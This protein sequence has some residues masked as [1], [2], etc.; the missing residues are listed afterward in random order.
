MRGS[1]GF[2]SA[3]RS[4][5]RRDHRRRLRSGQLT[6]EA[7]ESRQ[8]LTALQMTDNEQL[9]VELLNR[10]RMDPGGEAQRL[11][12][13]LNFDLVDGTLKPDPRQ[14]L[15]PQQMLIDS[16][17][18]H[19]QDMLDRNYFSHYTAGSK[20]GPQQRAE[21]LGYTG[22]VGEN[23]SWGGSTEPID[24]L[25]QVYDRHLNLWR[26][27]VHRRNLLDAGYDELG[28]GVR[29]GQY[30][31]GPTYNAS[32]VV[33]DFG[34]VS[35]KTYITGVVYSDLDNDQFYEDRKSTRL[36]SSHSSVSRMPS[37]A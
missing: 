5:L 28:V 13:D 18:A 3:V 31:S 22:F 21:L 25:E 26:S 15:A 30:V 33:T 4:I 11:G 20:N 37:S 29:Y 9:L 27:S 36:N 6:A 1:F 7:L 32:M 24:Q 35:G 14:P 23:L 10:A 19:A 34:K 16:S 2:L 8:L 17:G 12:I